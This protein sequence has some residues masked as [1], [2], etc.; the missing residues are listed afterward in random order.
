[1]RPKI[2]TML[3]L[4]LRG[5]NRFFSQNGWKRRI[6]LLK[7]VSGGV[8]MYCLF[9]YHLFCFLNCFWRGSFC[10]SLTQC[11]CTWHWVTWRNVTWSTTCWQELSVLSCTTCCGKHVCLHSSIH[12]QTQLEYEACTRL[13]WCL[14]C[15][16]TAA[17][18]STEQC[19]LSLVGRRILRE[20]SWDR[21]RSNVGCLFF[22]G[23]LIFFF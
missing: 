2:H 13:S 8:L 9:T 10:C 16:I 3:L 5:G 17:K 1:M 15:G 12:D 22:I 21:S 6:I 4:G 7:T 20:R 11:F 23:Q 19:W 18:K 14:L